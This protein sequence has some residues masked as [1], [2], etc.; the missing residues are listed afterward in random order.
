MKTMKKALA[1]VLMVALVMSCASVAFAST[2]I[3]TTGKC[4]LRTGPALGYSSITTV[5]KGTNLTA[6]S[7][8]TDDRGVKW[9]KVKYDGKTGWVSSVYC[10]K[11]SA[12]TSKKV[13][14]ATG[15]TYI[16]SNSNLNG[17]KLGVLHTG[18]RANYL[19]KSA[20]D[21]RGVRWYKVTYAG[22]TGWV[23]SVNSY[24]K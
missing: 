10:K 4:N 9:Y 22:I 12:P 2:S 23:S 17:K 20:L 14:V 15:N 13:V 19:N 6:T 5:P 21:S 16:R 7:S 18:E 8:K 3:Y 24:V 1:A 11:G